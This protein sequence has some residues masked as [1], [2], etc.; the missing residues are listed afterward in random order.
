[1]VGESP[2]GQSDPCVGMWEEKALRFG[3]TVLWEPETS[4]G[5]GEREM[6]GQPS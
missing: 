6:L 4:G 2:T 1:M 3:D 5:G